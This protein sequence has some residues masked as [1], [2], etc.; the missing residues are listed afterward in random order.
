MPIGRG[1]Y[2][3]SLSTRTKKGP[4]TEA[5]TKPGILLRHGIRVISPSLN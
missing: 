5:N 3:E 4:K 1:P 2:P